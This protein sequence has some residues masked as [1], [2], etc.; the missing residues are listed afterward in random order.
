MGVYD[1]RYSLPD[2]LPPHILTLGVQLLATVS[3]FEGL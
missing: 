3:P 2:E 1:Y